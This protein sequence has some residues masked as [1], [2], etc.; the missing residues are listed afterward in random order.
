MTQICYR[1]N[2]FP[3]TIIQ[4]AVWLYFPFPL[5]CRN[6]EDLLSERGIHVTNEA[7]R[8]WALKFG[9]AYQPVDKVGCGRFGVICR[10]GEF[11]LIL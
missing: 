6:V 8:R 1:R 7:V 4:H 10:R 3:G 11:A 2:C 5:S 9:S